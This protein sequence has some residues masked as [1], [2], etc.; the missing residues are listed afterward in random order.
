MV[1]FIIGLIIVAVIVVLIIQMEIETH[2]PAEIANILEE[3]YA[4]KELLL[5]VK[6]IAKI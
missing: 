4:V 3:V 5:L 1:Y 2:K 6:I